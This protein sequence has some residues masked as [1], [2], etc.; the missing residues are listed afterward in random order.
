MAA[1]GEIYIFL[2]V[3]SPPNPNL[4]GGNPSALPL[5]LQWGCAV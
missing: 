4:E 2:F 1:G 5:C 3:K